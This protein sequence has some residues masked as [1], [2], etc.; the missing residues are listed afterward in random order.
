MPMFM[1]TQKMKLISMMNTISAFVQCSTSNRNTLSEFFLISD[2]NMRWTEFETK[3][4]QCPV[5]FKGGLQWILQHHQRIKCFR[6]LSFFGPYFP[7]FGMG[8]QFKWGKIWTRKTSNTDL[9]HNIIACCSFFVMDLLSTDSYYLVLFGINEKSSSKQ[10]YSAKLM[11]WKFK[12][13]TMKSL[14]FLLK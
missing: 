8:V 14:W 3:L 12:M 1:M 11:F 6:I 2:S 10:M 13:S 4:H 5:P 9:V 7:A